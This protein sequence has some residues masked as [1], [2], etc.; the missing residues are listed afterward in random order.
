MTNITKCKCYSFAQFATNDMDD[1]QEKKN[2]NFNVRI[3]KLM[4]YTYKKGE[5]EKKNR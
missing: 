3:N 5:K 2:L 1:I 4:Q